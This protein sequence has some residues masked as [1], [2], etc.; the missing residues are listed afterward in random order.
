M[1]AVSDGC[2]KLGARAMP[3][4]QAGID[5]L[6]KN[7]RQ[8]AQSLVCAAFSEAADYYGQ[9]RPSVVILRVDAEQLVG[10]L[11]AYERLVHLDGRQ[12]LIGMVG[13]IVVSTEC[14]RQGVCKNLIA[15]AH[16]CFARRLI[17][18]SVLFAY[19]PNIY[20]S[21]GYM[22]MRNLTR[23]VDRDG[24]SKEFVYRGGMVAELS[25]TPWPHEFLDLNG[26]AV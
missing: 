17:E 15:E 12:I 24:N 6:P 19:D 13:D 16:L 26:P 1:Q 23:F 25:G 2:W 10:H 9:W 4:L 21:S 11:A 14:R 3:I 7:L 20:R 18:F 8:Q 22:P 5:E